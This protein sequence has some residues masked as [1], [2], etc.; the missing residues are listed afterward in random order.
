V[1]GIVQ[2]G[3]NRWDAEKR[4]QFKEAIVG[5]SWE[6]TGIERTEIN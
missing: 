1:V 4:E 5:T 2:D 3:L 6:Y